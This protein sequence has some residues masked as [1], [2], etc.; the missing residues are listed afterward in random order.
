MSEFG[1]ANWSIYVTMAY[2]VVFCALLAFSV[3][4]FKKR[5]QCLQNL[6]DEG[7][8]ADSGSDDRQLGELK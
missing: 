8:L 6:K 7:F 4:S 2:G 3:W 1:N 5:E